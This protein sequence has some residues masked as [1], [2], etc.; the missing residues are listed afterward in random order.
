MAQ[1]SKTPAPL[2]EAQL[3]VQ[4]VDALAACDAARPRLRRA[5]MTAD[6][7]TTPVRAEITALEARVAEL[8]RL[9]TQLAAARERDAAADIENAAARYA[10]NA[11]GRLEDLLAA[12]QPPPHPGA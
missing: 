2:T 8:K 4:L 5:L 1:N 10:V 7:D 11:L 9:G 12:L 3:H 6:E